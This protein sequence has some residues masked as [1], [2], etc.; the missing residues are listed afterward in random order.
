M[1]RWKQLLMSGTIVASVLAM[2]ACGGTW[3]VYA[4]R[5]HT[6]QI[7]MGGEIGGTWLDRS[8]ASIDV[9]S[10]RFDVAGSDIPL[11]ATGIVAVTVKDGAGGTVG[12]SSFGWRRVGTQLV[13]TDP[14][15][16]SRWL[17]AYPNAVHAEYV[18]PGFSMPTDGRSHT[19]ATAIRY[20]GDVKASARSTF[21]NTCPPYPTPQPCIPF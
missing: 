4:K 2:S 9:G 15:A 5:H 6:N 18:I 8:V 14:G 3:K 17:S 20:G 10:L 13:V 12:S 11:P 7:E 1:I 21:A 19:V 16:L